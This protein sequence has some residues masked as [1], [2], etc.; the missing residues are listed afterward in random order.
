[1]QNAEFTRSTD[2]IGNLGLDAQNTSSIN[3]K[4]QDE[5]HMTSD[6]AFTSFGSTMWSG[7]YKGVPNRPIFRCV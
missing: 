2:Y 4:W 3:L 7:V 5:L 1:M 6:L